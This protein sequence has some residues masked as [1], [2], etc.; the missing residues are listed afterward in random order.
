VNDIRRR[1]SDSRQGRT[2]NDATDP[3]SQRWM[4]T[5]DC[6]IRMRRSGSCL[7]AEEQIGL[8]SIGVV[9]NMGRGRLDLQSA[10]NCSAPL[11]SRRPPTLKQRTR[12]LADVLAGHGNS[13]QHVKGCAAVG[14]PHNETTH[15][16]VGP[17]SVRSHDRASRL[18]MSSPPAL[19][20]NTGQQRSEGYGSLECEL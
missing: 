9:L 17:P 6:D 4:P 13:P 15:R 14:Q 16:S 11:R 10:G 3:P 19:N 7:V 18:G 12:N 8:V 1:V 2:D 20:F 5:A